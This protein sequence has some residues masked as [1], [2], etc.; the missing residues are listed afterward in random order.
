[1]WQIFSRYFLCF[2]PSKFHGRGQTHFSVKTAILTCL[3]KSYGT[4]GL[5]PTHAIRFSL[6]GYFR[7][8]YGGSNTPSYSGYF[9][10]LYGGSNTPSWRETRL[11]G[12]SP[13]RPLKKKRMANSPNGAN[14]H[15]GDGV[16]SHTP[17]GVENIAAPRVRMGSAHRTR[18]PTQ[19][20]R[21]PKFQRRIS[22]FATR[23]SKAPSRKSP[24]SHP[25]SES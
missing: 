14:R 21:F 10:R 18:H 3:K 5:T 7:R 8:L 11:F 17:H 16:C 6:S 23:K 19:K 1:M 12:K 9:C 15:T 24:P 22:A 25:K 2:C 13:P 4:R 20:R